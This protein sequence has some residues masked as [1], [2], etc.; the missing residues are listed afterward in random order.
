MGL[1]VEKNPDYDSFLE[2]VN[3]SADNYLG[4]ASRVL[5]NL[6]ADDL[7]KNAMVHPDG[8]LK[9][10]IGPNNWVHDG[11]VRL[12]LWIPGREGTKQPHSHPWHLA[13]WVV[14]GS[15]NEYLPK[16]HEVTDGQLAHYRIAY[17]SSTDQRL[18]VTRIG[19]SVFTTETGSLQT[20]PEG[21]IHALPA[22]P[23]HMSAPDGRG[24]V[25]LAV[26]SPRFKDEAE[27]W[28]PNADPYIETINSDEIDGIMQVI[29]GIRGN[30]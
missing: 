13:S 24:G 18:G 17:P 22:G 14:A 26:M 27:F 19:E 1:S 16:L 3:R 7:R 10:Q 11:Q 2:S 12:H 8:F 28:A 20:T 30:L 5:K 6:T 9:L 23:T 4:A 21:G 25:T 29:S 15:Y